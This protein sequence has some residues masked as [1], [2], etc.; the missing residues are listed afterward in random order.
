MVGARTSVVVESAVESFM[1][2]VASK[3]RT[4]KMKMNIK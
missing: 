2:L 3:M 1:M 4:K